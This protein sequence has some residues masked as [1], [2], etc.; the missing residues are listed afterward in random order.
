MTI[1]ISVR[2]QSPEK[3]APSKINVGTRKRPNVI[4]VLAIVMWGTIASGAHADIG[5]TP[6]R[7]WVFAVGILQWKHPDI[8]VSVPEAMPDR[9]D[10]RLIE[11]L[12]A[13][14]I[15][16]LATHTSRITTP[17]MTMRATGR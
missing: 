1:E 13:T 4:V 8:Y 7:T 5:W 6:S 17:A 9:A 16:R 10:R 15:E 14:A 12:K 2:G 11:A 3:P